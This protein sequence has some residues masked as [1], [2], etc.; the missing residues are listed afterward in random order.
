MSRPD[1]SGRDTP[2][3]RETSARD[4]D[5]ILTARE[6]EQYEREISYLKKETD[7]QQCIIDRYEVE[8]D[9]LREDKNKLYALLDSANEEKKMLIAGDRDSKEVMKNNNSLIAYLS[10][11]FKGKAEIAEPQIEPPYRVSNPIDVLA[12]DERTN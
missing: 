6:R 12:G 3:E 7:L 11:F 4:N 10:Q 5:G 1:A 8:N 9:G 2:N